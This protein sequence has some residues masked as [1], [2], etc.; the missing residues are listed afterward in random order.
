MSKAISN[1]H[2]EEKLASVAAEIALDGYKGPGTSEFP[3]SPGLEALVKAGSQLWF[4]TGNKAEAQPLWARQVRG[5]TTNNTLVNQ[6]VQTG[7]MDSV[8]GTAARRLK[9]AY[10]GMSER[11]LV[12]ET[13]FI[14]NARIALELVEIFG[15]TVSVELHPD[16]ADDWRMTIEFGKRYF[17]ICPERFL[18]K[19]P[20]TPD[21]FIGVRKLSDAGVPVN[22]TLG[23]SARQN[24][25]AALFSRPAYVN[26]F[27]GRLGV[28][29]KDNNL[30]SGENVGERV[31]LVSQ[32]EVEKL[33]EEG[34]APSQQI[35]A[36]IRTGRQVKELAGVDVLTI[37]PKAARE[38]LDANPDPADVRRLS[39]ADFPVE[40]TAN[41]SGKG[42]VETFWE[43][44]DA[45]RT[46][47]RA[48]SEKVSSFD[49]GD[50]ILS[51]A[52]E[53]GVNDF[54][55]KWLPGD[56][57]EIQK[58]GKIPDLH[59]WCDVAAADDMMTQAALQSFAVDQGE[60][61]ARIARLIAG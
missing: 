12:I 43:V 19:V 16:L 52:A 51:F 57:R 58:G 32:E 11:D 60:L 10:P 21:G 23:F 34:A 18:V 6:V 28:V 15:A 27:L 14:L 25:F 4:D 53:C 45:F 26:V 54:F 8:I 41:V 1:L 2:C 42:R 35:A 40:L 30:G 55:R 47:A 59:R 50:K 13:G 29:V 31:C 46:F 20:M 36:S 3:D 56:Q 61:D 7:V 38:Y 37:P 33:R 9:E 49:T 44:P 39:S 24:Y 48:A 22:F 17:A 5:L